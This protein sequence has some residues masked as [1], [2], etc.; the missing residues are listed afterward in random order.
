MKVLFSYDARISTIKIKNASAEKY[1]TDNNK[2]IKQVVKQKILPFDLISPIIEIINTANIKIIV[3][4]SI[5]N[6]TVDPKSNTPEKDKK[7]NETLISENTID[8]VGNTF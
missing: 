3:A 2:V 8:N 7:Q 6:I 1:N 5:V 4:N